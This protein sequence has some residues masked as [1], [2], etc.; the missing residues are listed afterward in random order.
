MSNMYNVSSFLISLILIAASIAIAALCKGKE[1]KRKQF[2]YI[3]VCVSA[4]YIAGTALILT[5]TFLLLIIGILF[6]FCALLS[7]LVLLCL[8]IFKHYG[9]TCGD[10]LADDF[11]EA[12]FKAS[13][14]AEKAYS[15]VKEMAEGVIHGT[16]PHKDDNQKPDPADEKC[17]GTG[18]KEA[19]KKAG[20]NRDIDANEASAGSMNG[21]AQVKDS[22]DA[23]GNA[24]RESSHD[25]CGDPAKKAQRND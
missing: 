7:I 5:R 22:S 1:E 11:T 16:K 10:G 21:N 14:V 4:I 18:D 9:I 6:H 17:D 13:D 2:F 25:A 24:D 23:A 12:V 8:F 15:S 3:F 20:T 19:E